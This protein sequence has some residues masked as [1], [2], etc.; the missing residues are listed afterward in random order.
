MKKTLL[1]LLLLLLTLSFSSALA[2]HDHVDIDGAEVLISGYRAPTETEDGSTGDEVCSVCGEVIKKASPIPAVGKQREKAKEENIT[3]QPPVRT[4]APETPNTPV[5][6]ARPTKEPT[7][8]PPTAPPTANPPPPQPPPPGAPAAPPPPPEAPA[9]APK[10]KTAE[11][12][13]Q[14]DLSGEEKNTAFKPPEDQ[15]SAGGSSSFSPA[16]GSSPGGASRRRSSSANQ[17]APSPRDLDAYPIFSSRFPWRRLPMSPEPDIL[18]TP[19]GELIW[20]PRPEAS[21][22]LMMLQL[23]DPQ[24]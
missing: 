15:G 9:P 16:A 18:L 5:P 21:S 7:P 24:P 22:P 14:P 6:T 10:K 3:P 11:Q 2:F 4:Q 19:A 1:F 13:P 8:P 17:P 12:T 23:P 20:S